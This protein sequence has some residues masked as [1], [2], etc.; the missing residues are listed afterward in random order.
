MN[1]CKFLSFIELKELRDWF[2][3]VSLSIW[4]ILVRKLLCISITE[5]N[6]S[7]FRLRSNFLFSLVFHSWILIRDLLILAFPRWSGAY[8]LA[9]LHSML[10]SV[11]SWFSPELDKF[12][13]SDFGVQPK[14][15][16]LILPFQLFD[17]VGPKLNQPRVNIH[18][19]KFSWY[20][21]QQTAVS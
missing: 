9:Y 6:F 7:S 5:S 8:F 4:L 17:M 20:E 16:N 11:I 21:T 19:R 14:F 18:S 13:A 1:R 10:I 3:I 15:W 12:L 2:I